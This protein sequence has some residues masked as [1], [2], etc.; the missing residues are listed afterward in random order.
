MTL[1]SDFNSYLEEKG[2][3]S[4][5]TPQVL[6]EIERYTKL[7]TDARP[8]ITDMYKAAVE[9]IF[10]NNENLLPYAQDIFEKV[11]DKYTGTNPKL[12]AVKDNVLEMARRKSPGEAAATDKAVESEAF[13]NEIKD[14]ILANDMPAGEEPVFESFMKNANKFVEEGSITVDNLIDILDFALKNDVKVGVDNRPAI[15]LINEWEKTQGRG[16]DFV[17]HA[18]DNKYKLNGESAI[19]WAVRN[20][21]EIDGKPAFIYAVEDLG[22]DQ[23]KLFKW[24]VKND[25]NINGVLAIKLAVKNDIE[26]D[27]KPALVYAV[28][29]LGKNQNTMLKYAIKNDINIAGKP[30]VEW[31][32]LNDKTIDGKAPMEYATNIN[33]TVGGMDLMEWVGKNADRLVGE[34][35]PSERVV[36]RHTEKVLNDNLATSQPSIK[37]R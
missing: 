36:G 26:I 27:G 32:F 24:A 34:K 19:K 1:Q 15:E 28:E 4:K 8:K 37:V 13:V 25:I 20:D 6:I 10:S 29:D 2:L 7:A 21:V 3:E 23:D 22:N 18:I 16:G 5:V 11:F 35:T 30:A 33:A 14:A 31:A 12:N 17:K 9:S